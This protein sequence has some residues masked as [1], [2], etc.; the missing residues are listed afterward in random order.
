MKKWTTI[1]QEDESEITD[2]DCEIKE[3]TSNTG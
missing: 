3:L 2:V 1:P